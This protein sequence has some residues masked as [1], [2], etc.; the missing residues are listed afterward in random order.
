MQGCTE[1]HSSYD[2]CFSLSKDVAVWL[3]AQRLFK[4]SISRMRSELILEHHTGGTARSKKDD[5]RLYLMGC[6]R[7]SAIKV[8][9]DI[10]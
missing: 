2:S 7:R 5:W 10:A 6:D 1:L 4:P 9:A 3:Y 8:Q